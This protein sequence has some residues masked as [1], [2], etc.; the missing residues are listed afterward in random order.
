MPR[1]PDTK[2][3]SSRSVKQKENPVGTKDLK[4]RKPKDKRPKDIRPKW[5]KDPKDIRPN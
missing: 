1:C 4:D 5:T 2:P 3:A